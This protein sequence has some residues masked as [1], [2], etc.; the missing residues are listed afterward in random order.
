MMMGI[1]R[2]L[3]SRRQRHA[4]LILAILAAREEGRFGYDMWRQS[5]IPSGAMYVALGHLE[6]EGLVTTGWAE[7]DA[8]RT[9]RLYRITPEGRLA[10]ARG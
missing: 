4:D 2:A 3:Q 1:R 8:G 5:G 10:A 7:D 9:R 6:R